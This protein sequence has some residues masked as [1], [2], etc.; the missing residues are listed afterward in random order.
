MGYFRVSG[1]LKYK[2]IL[3]IEDNRKSLLYEDQ[4]LEKWF[5]NKKSEWWCDKVQI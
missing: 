1:A 3:Y 4:T 5:G 2:K